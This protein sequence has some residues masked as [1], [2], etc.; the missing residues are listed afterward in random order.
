MGYGLC[1]D[2]N[3]TKHQD[4]KRFSKLTNSMFVNY[5]H[6]PLNGVLKINEDDCPWFIAIPREVEVVE[7]PKQDLQSLLQELSGA[8]E[9]DC[10]SCKI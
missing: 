1:K 6:V 9:E 7:E 10:E 2:T 4:C 8:E 5:Q 3:C